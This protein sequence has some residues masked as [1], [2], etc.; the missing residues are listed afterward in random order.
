MALDVKAALARLGD[1][2]ALFRE[3]VGF[4]DE[5]HP[6]FVEALK[7]AVAARD[8]EAIH[9]TAH[10]LKGL[11]ASLGATEVVGVLAKLERLG[12][13]KDLS[14]L[15]ELMARLQSEM[16]ELD[17]EL[18]PYRVPATPSGRAR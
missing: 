12:R 8:G 10:G 16:R 3:F 13:S 5:D 4:Y 18:R 15:V 1:D 2:E 17:Q 7:A 14:E 11:A 9:H 6:R